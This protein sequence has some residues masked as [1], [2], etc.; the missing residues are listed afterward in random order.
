MGSHGKVSS[1]RDGGPKGELLRSLA[2]VTTQY[3]SLRPGPQQKKLQGEMPSGVDMASVP[4]NRAPDGI[5]AK[6]GDVSRGPGESTCRKPAGWKQAETA[7]WVLSGGTA[8]TERDLEDTQTR[9]L[10]GQRG[11]MVPGAGRGAG[12]NST[13]EAKGAVRPKDGRR[14]VKSCK[15]AKSRRAGGKSPVPS[16]VTAGI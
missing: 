10:Q 1:S 3:H 15:M 4:G 7:Q 16:A 9:N 12:K 6:Q 5:A 11:R 8:C 14:Q 13:T 2:Q